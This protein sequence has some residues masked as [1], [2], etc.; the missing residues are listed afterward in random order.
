[1]LLQYEGTQATSIRLEYRANYNGRLTIN[2]RRKINSNQTTF[3]PSD[4]N[5]SV[6]I[7]PIFSEPS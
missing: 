1:M 4:F 6:F 2:D 7:G 3:N 5:P